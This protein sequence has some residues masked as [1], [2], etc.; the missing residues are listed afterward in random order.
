MKEISEEWASG[1]Y[2]EMAKNKEEASIISVYM[3]STEGLTWMADFSIGQEAFADMMVTTLNEKADRSD[4][5]DG[6]FMRS[7]KDA[8]LFR[9]GEQCPQSL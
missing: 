2:M 4:F 7:N 1:A 8:N 3:E 6:L 5:G 9:G